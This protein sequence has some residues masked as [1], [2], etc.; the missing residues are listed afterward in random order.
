MSRKR[1]IR[2]RM[3]EMADSRRNP[4]KP[5]P[6]SIFEAAQLIGKFSGQRIDL[7][8]ANIQ[9]EFGVCGWILTILSYLLIFFTL[10]IS[11]CMCIKVVQEYERAV[12]F[13]LGRLMPGGAKGPGI[14]FIVPCIDTYRK[15]DLRVLSFE[16]PPQEILSKDSVTVAVDAVVYFRISNATISVTNVEDAARSTKLLAQTTLRNI[17]GTKTLAEML[18]DREAISHQMQ[19][20]LDEATE[21][22]GVKVERVEVKDVRLPVQLQRAMAAEAEAAR[23][24]RAKVIVAEGEQKASRALKEAAEVIAESPSALQLRYLQTLNSISAEKNS[25]IIFPFPIDLLSAFLQRTPPKVEEPPSLPKKIRS[26]CLYKYPDWVQGMVGSEGGGGHGHSHGGGGGGLGS[27]QGAFHPSQAGSGPSTTTTSGRP[28][29]RS[30]REAQF[31]SAAPPISAPNQ[32]QTSVSQLDPGSRSGQQSRRSSKPVGAGANSLL[33]QAIANRMMPHATTSDGGE[34][35]AAPNIGQST[36]SATSSTTEPA[37]IHRTDSS[38]MSKSVLLNPAWYRDDQGRTGYKTSDWEKVSN[39]QKDVVKQSKKKRKESKNEG[40][41]IKELDTDLLSQTSSE[42]VESGSDNKS[43][44]SILSDQKDPNDSKVDKKAAKA[45]EKERK[46]LEKEKKKLEKAQKKKEAEEEKKLKKKKGSSTNISGISENSE[47]SEIGEHESVEMKTIEKKKEK[48]AAT[49]TLTMVSKD[50]TSKSSKQETAH[51][52]SAP[53]KSEDSVS[54]EFE[55]AQKESS[56]R[57]KESSRDE[58]ADK[59]SK[60][61]GRPPSGTTHSSV[62]KLKAESLKK[63]EPRR[64]TIGDRRDSSMSELSRGSF[65]SV[66]FNDR[67]QTHE[68]ERNSSVYTSSED[69]AAIMSDDEMSKPS[70]AKMKKKLT[71]LQQSPSQQ[72]RQEH[73]DIYDDDDLDDFEEQERLALLAAQGYDFRREMQYRE[74]GDIEY[75]NE[76]EE[77][78]NEEEEEDTLS[79]NSYYAEDVEGADIYLRNEHSF[80]ETDPNMQTQMQNMAGYEW[81]DRAMMGSMGKLHGDDS[82][83]SSLLLNYNLPRSASGY[84]EPPPEASHMNFS[85]EEAILNRQA[86]ALH[87][88]QLLQQLQKL[89]QQH[90]QKEV[91]GEHKLS[92]PT[93]GVLRQ[94]ATQRSIYENVTTGDAPSQPQSLIIPQSPSAKNKM[95][96]TEFF[97]QTPSNV[98]SKTIMAASS[99]GQ[100]IQ[101]LGSTDSNATVRVEDEM[102]KKFVARFGVRKAPI[103]REEDPADPKHGKVMGS[104]ESMNSTDSRESVVSAASIKAEALAR[105]NFNY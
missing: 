90:P 84:F 35:S 30:M 105:R 36:S 92:P 53:N 26:C 102:R 43:N 22:W 103:A 39:Q 61:E 88:Q 54:K 86:Q 73:V 14:F 72:I 44:N 21:P 98:V 77:E 65:K 59:E 58:E 15:V 66:T 7:L 12:I 8:S 38:E 29:L 34:S 62:R 2:E 13:R 3:A 32:S 75:D 78:E 28:L 10:P 60:P 51:K 27:S 83:S 49:I 64:K 93:G 79:Q 56:K 95:A 71:M 24:A 50:K 52:N 1:S 67:V 18:S 16:V 87:Q 97:T 20:T 74:D 55:D 5:T 104:Q 100:S 96:R 89:P 31:H 99:D 11:A 45:L 81:F 17:L 80:L 9:N 68:I 42:K 82:A 94:T 23:E 63:S 4:K 41:V 46:K 33:K 85:Y 19:T 37:K 91:A 48:A 101:S 6:P 57:K 25:T 69:D 47:I 70:Q 76:S 40:E